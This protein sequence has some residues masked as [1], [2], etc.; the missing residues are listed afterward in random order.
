[1]LGL[2]PSSVAVRN[3]LLGTGRLFPSRGRGLAAGE[4]ARLRNGLLDD[5][6]TAFGGDCRPSSETRARGQ[7][8]VQIDSSSRLRYRK[9]PLSASSLRERTGLS[10]LVGTAAISDMAIMGF[11]RDGGVLGREE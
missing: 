10:S 3:G 5:R 7:Q 2:A 6:L 8:S 9:W 4:I 1:M 11:R